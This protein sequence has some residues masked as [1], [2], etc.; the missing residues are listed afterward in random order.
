MQPSCDLFQ[1]VV[2]DTLDLLA[3]RRH[4]AD[5]VEAADR[6]LVQ[7]P[8][9]LVVARHAALTIAKDVDRAQVE[10]LTIVPDQVLQRLRVVVQADGARMGDAE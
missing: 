7:Q 4:V 9:E 1:I 5:L 2:V 3:P 6:G 10:L 8:E